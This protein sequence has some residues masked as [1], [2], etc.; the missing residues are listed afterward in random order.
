MPA[1]SKSQQR[2]FGMI[3]AYKSGKLKDAPKGIREAAQHVSD[4]D[5]RDFAETKHKGLPERKKKMKKSAA[6]IAGFMTECA[7]RDVDPDMAYE[8][9]KKAGFLGMAGRYA[10]D[11]IRHPVKAGKRYLQLLR[12]G[13]S[14]MLGDYRRAMKALDAG[15]EG[16]LAKKNSKMYQAYRE[17]QDAIYRGARDP[18]WLPPNKAKVFRGEKNVPLFVLRG[19]GEKGSAGSASEL[20]KVLAAQLGTGVAAGGALAAGASQL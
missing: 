2:L 16:A 9:C 7:R 12:G 14:R 5:A 8:M 1:R 17:I 18:N 3:H 19:L 10:K 4:E 6:W 15:A 13:D 11:V 20:R